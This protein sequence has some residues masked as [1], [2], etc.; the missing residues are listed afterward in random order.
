MFL[1][2]NTVLTYSCHKKNK[3]VRNVGVIAIANRQLYILHQNSTMRRFAYTELIERP[4]QG[5]IKFLHEVCATF[6][7]ARRTT[8]TVEQNAGQLI[9]NAVFKLLLDRNNIRNNQTCQ[10]F[11]ERYHD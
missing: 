2:D 3:S 5:S 8:L 7:N 10:G 4:E 1:A 11:V 6:L 9:D